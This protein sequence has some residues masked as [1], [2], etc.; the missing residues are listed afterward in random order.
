MIATS[1]LAG[2]TD[3]VTY[4]SYYHFINFQN[5][6]LHA[7][8]YFLFVFDFPKMEARNLFGVNNVLVLV[9]KY[10]VYFLLSI[11]R[12]EIIVFSA[13]EHIN[14]VSAYLLQTGMH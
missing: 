11:V 1:V 4:C 9:L 10:I 7:Q 2:V 12:N 6:M 13:F 8:L 5:V 14:T 3:P